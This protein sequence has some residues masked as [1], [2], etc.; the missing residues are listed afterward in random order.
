MEILKT[1]LLIRKWKKHEELVTASA[2]EN[3]VR[4]LMASEE[5]DEIRK[6][7]EKLGVVVME[8]IEKG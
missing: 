8:S 4:K 3:V 7:A 1:G 2:I 6:R 5:G